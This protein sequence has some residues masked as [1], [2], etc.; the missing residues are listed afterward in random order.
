MKKGEKI[1]DHDQY[2]GFRRFS[3]VFLF[4]ILLIGIVLGY[5][6]LVS[7]P[8]SH[9]DPR[10]AIP[11]KTV[12][13]IESD[14]LPSLIHELGTESKIWNELAELD[15][16]R[17]FSTRLKILDSIVNMNKQLAGLFSE[18]I[19]ITISLKS[20]RTP[21]F[22]FIIPV[23]VNNQKDQILQHFG[24]NTGN[25]KYTRRRYRSNNVYDLS[26][27]G[28]TGVNNFSF[29]IIRGIIIGSF[30]GELVEESISQIN[31][32]N[33]II[34]QTEFKEV[35]RTVG[36]KV[37]ANLFVNYK[38]LPQLIDFFSSGNSVLRGTKLT[39]FADWGAFDVEF[40]PNRIIL[41]GFTSISDS[42]TRKLDL[43]RGQEPVEFTSPMFLPSEVSLFKLYGFSD[44]E[45]FF[46]QLNQ[47]FENDRSL[48]TLA[49][50]KTSLLNKFRIDLD[51]SFS[52]FISN[53]YGM[54]VLSHERNY[55]FMKLKSQS[56]AEDGF[57]NWINTYAAQ[58]GL[59]AGDF[60][61]YARIDNNTTIPVY[62]LPFG[63]IPALVFGDEF[64]LDENNYFTFINNYIVFSNSFDELKY[65][66]YQVILG[67]TISMDPSFISLKEHISS[68]SNYFIFFKPYTSLEQ[69]LPSLTE[70]SR[71]TIRGQSDRLSKFNA[72]TI[73]FSAADNL[74]YNRIFINYT[75]NLKDNVNTVWE[76]RLDTIINFK[77]AILLNHNTGEK[78][79]FVQDSH[80]QI[81]LL[82]NAG[83]I[84]W[85]QKI[86]GPILSEVVQVDYFRNNKL[87]YLFNTS[88]KIYLVDR[89]GNP[90]EKFPV[91]LR[92]GATAG[93]NV[94]D[95]DNDKTIRMCIPCEDM[96]IY[97]YDKEG[98]VIPGWKP[99]KTDNVISRPVQHYRIGNRDFIIAIDEYKFYI[100][101][102][103]GNIRINPTTNFPVSSKNIFYPDLSMGISAAG[104]V[105]T[106]TMGNIMKVYLNGKV[107]KLVEQKLHS[108]HYFILTDLNGDNLN[109]YVFTS[110]KEFFVENSRG[111]KNF[112]HDLTEN[113]EIK[114]VIYKFS[115]TDNKVGI[116]YN[117]E[118]I[119]YLYN[120]DGSLYKGFP[121]EGS[122]AFSISSFPELRGR[123]NLIVGSR[124][125]FLYNY[126]VQ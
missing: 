97:M 74:F 19:I 93:M 109:E 102:R 124:N 84:L 2:R 116:V 23:S 101:D 69:I 71:E 30:S 106:D 27:S 16:L 29:S 87:Q 103:K 67:N 57:K 65:F 22:L 26:W 117:K 14:K 7:K 59:K 60:L 123:F 56:I 24:K 86:D 96:N 37:T 34:V 45:L 35:T 48:K 77:P 90:V 98:K 114:P 76:S 125:N 9:I 62:N 119:I 52:E 82:S 79:I 18:K 120:K 66:I 31:S 110:G 54:A 21:G 78:E 113:I 111:I 33:K 13:F 20:N 100:L 4:A 63:N 121:L 107:E 39:D 70:K 28:S 80:N 89:N 91:D 49:A 75:G 10:L 64:G 61:F 43:L 50:Q 55:F 81:Y 122:C 1:S 85:K 118:G 32:Q 105:T 88:N 104:F 99:D 44:R 94:F 46:K 6:W 68:L 25:F 53:E 3:N 42:V 51:K 12:A 11:L 47:N 95:Y 126:S 83:L 108:D 8:L 73:Q 40:F 5:L 17:T 112:S 41:N 72:I 36:E 115:A 38:N 15:Q 58:N 92:S